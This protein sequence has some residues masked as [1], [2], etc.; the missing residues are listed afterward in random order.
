MITFLAD[1]HFNNFTPFAKTLK[2]G[3]NSRLQNIL[4]AVRYLI[5]KGKKGYGS[6]DV[7]IVGDVFD[8]HRAINVQVLDRVVS[9]FQSLS[10]DFN[11][12]FIAGNHDI[13]SSGDGSCSLM[14]FSEFATVITQTE[15]KRVC[16]FDFGCIPYTDDV[17]RVRRDLKH[18]FNSCHYI[19]AHIGLSQGKVGPLH[20]EIP[21]HF[22]V[23]DLSPDKY[24]AFFLGH[25]HG[26]QTIG[27]N[28]HYIGSPVQHNFGERNNNVGGLVLLGDGE[29]LPLFNEH[30]PK[31]VQVDMSDKSSADTSWRS[32]DYVKAIVRSKEDADVFKESANITS[33]LT[34]IK[35]TES[36]EERLDV[37]GLSVSDT[38]RAYMEMQNIPEKDHERYL[39]V[40][41]DILREVGH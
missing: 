36:Y 1:L 4:D 9:L 35:A 5:L 29:I 21:G 2:D 37:S 34:V 40:G 13:S 6:K 38:L 16:G 33:L 24:E 19:A 7:F 8:S 25:Y 26:Q 11:F 18:N 20:L 22:D 15:V 30:S 14:A 12:Y 32:T 31:F 28:I 39:S 17:K 10:K 41:L 27:D 23:E 3:T